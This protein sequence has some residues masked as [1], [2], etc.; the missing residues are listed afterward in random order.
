MK[1]LLFGMS[2]LPTEVTEDMVMYPNQLWVSSYLG[3]EA[4]SH[5]HIRAGFARGWIAK[6]CGPAHLSA[7]HD[8]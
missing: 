1:Q 3:A 7:Q 8:R 6:L 5:V 2:P 4:V